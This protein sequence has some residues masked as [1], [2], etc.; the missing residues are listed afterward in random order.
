MITGVNLA[1]WHMMHC[2]MT[3]P[4]NQSRSHAGED[5]AALDGLT[6][7]IDDRRIQR[8]G[9]VGLVYRLVIRGS[10]SP[11]KRRLS[12][13]KRKHRA[14]QARGRNQTSFPSHPRYITASRSPGRPLY[15][16]LPSACILTRSAAAGRVRLSC[17]GLS[18]SKKRSIVRWMAAVT[19]PPGAIQGA[20]YA[21]FWGAGA[22]VPLIRAT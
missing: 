19:M 22:P 8:R 16:A 11:L 12:S 18:A 2:D 4:T 6:S 10:R 15:L 7:E 5:R 20:G 21:S 14:A 13:L 1:P 3:R 17:W 9:L